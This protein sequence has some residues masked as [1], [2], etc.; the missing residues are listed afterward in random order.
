MIQSIAFQTNILALNAAVEAARAGDQGKGF[1]VVASEVRNLA[2]TSSKAADDITTIV[3]STIEKINSGYETVAESSSLL[4]EINNLVIDVSNSLVSIANAEKEEK[5]NI[6]QI[7]ISVAS[8]ND[9]TQRNSSLAN[10]SAVSS[11]EILNKTEHIAE[12]ISYFKF[13]N[14]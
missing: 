2:Q 4:N 14:V 13:K 8:I 3:E 7:N 6:E 9:I 12:N 11:K 5:D 10:D 1:A